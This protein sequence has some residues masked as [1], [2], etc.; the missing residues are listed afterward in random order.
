MRRSGVPPTNQ[1]SLIRHKLYF[2]YSRPKTSSHNCSLIRHRFFT[3]RGKLRIGSRILSQCLTPTVGSHFERNHFLFLP[4]IPEASRPSQGKREAIRTEKG[5]VHLKELT[6]FGK[7]K[8]LRA[9]S[10][11]ENLRG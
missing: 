1:F 2:R 3:R 6:L 4:L 5:V 10:N 8:F 7:G 11:F 9:L